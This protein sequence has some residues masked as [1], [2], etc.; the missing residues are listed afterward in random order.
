MAVYDKEEEM[1]FSLT[2]AQL[3]IRKAAREFAEEEFLNIAEECDM[4][5]TFNLELLRKA[6]IGIYRV[7]LYKKYGGARW[8][9]PLRALE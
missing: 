1:D 2:Q 5:E 4:D 8:H 9:L 3:D 6:S 7:F